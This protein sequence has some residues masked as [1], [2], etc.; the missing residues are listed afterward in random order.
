[1]SHKWHYVSFNILANGVLNFLSSKSK[2]NRPSYKQRR[3]TDDQSAV[4]FTLHG[5]CEDGTRQMFKTKPFFIGLLL[6][7]MT[8]PGHVF[9]KKVYKIDNCRITSISQSEK[10]NF[11]TLNCMGSQ[12]TVTVVNDLFLRVP[13][14]YFTTLLGPARTGQMFTVQFKLEKNPYVKGY[15]VGLSITEPGNLA[16]EKKSRHTKMNNQTRK[17]CTVTQASSETNGMYCTLRCL[18]QKKKNVKIYK[19]TPFLTTSSSIY[20]TCLI[21]MVHERTVDVQFRKWSKKKSWTDSKKG[22]KK[23]VKAL[24]FLHTISIK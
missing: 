13:P 17:S 8:F 21:A 18:S 20:Q 19:K 23:T 9:A 6:S 11:V 10:F 14:R 22:L 4:G 5:V 16:G 12:R 24:G 1:M 7:L 3:C 15:V 2:V